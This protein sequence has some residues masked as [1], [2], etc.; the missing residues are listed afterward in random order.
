MG[1]SILEDGKIH[2]FE[3]NLLE[4]LRDLMYISDVEC[5]NCK[6]K[7]FRQN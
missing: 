1:N 5:G 2:D 3:S 7:S 4:D 6:K